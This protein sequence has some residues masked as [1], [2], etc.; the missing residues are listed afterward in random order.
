[1]QLTITEVGTVYKIERFVSNSFVDRHSFDA[2]TDPD[3]T[4]YF[5]ADPD[6]DPT[7]CLT[8]NVKSVFFTFFHSC[9]SLHSFI[10]FVFVI[11]DKKV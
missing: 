11:E 4:F 6:P 10:F 8:H 2:H 5:N 9:A 3:P 1:M 7:T